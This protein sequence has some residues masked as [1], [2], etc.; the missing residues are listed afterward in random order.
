M[1][2]IVFALLTAATFSFFIHSVWTSWKR[3]KNIGQGAEENR[4][5]NPIARLKYVF[6]T[7]KYVFRL[8]KAS[9][10]QSCLNLERSFAASAYKSES[11]TQS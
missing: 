1:M 2:S 8:N 4:S 9:T 6:W 5:T 11:S 7:E 3:M 10:V